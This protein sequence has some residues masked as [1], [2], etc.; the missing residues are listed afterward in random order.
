[1]DNLFTFHPMPPE[2]VSPGAW[3]RFAAGLAAFL[4]L[5]L[6][7]TRAER[8]GD[9]IEYGAMAVALSQHGTPDVRAADAEL[10][11]QYSP[12]AGIA[13]MFERLRD[14]IRRGDAVPLPG[15]QR[16]SGGTYSIHFFAYPALAA[17]PLRALHAAG[18]DPFKAFQIVNY[19]ALA[20]LGLALL[21]LTAS[22][23]RAA[24]AFA[25]VLAGG[26][27]LYANWCSPEILSAALLLSGLVLS[28]TGRPLAGGLLAGVAAMH[29]PSIVC[30]AVCAPLLAFADPAG[31][32]G[33]ARPAWRRLAA[34]SLLQ[35]ALAA[36]PF[37]FFQWRFGTP[38]LIGKGYTDFHLVSG[39]RLVSYY[40]DLNQGMVVGLAAI[41]LL[42][43]AGTRAR[44][45][46]TAAALAVTA[47]F[48][49]G[50]A[51][52]TLVMTNWNAGANGMLRY[53][54]WG[55]APLLYL[56]FARWRGLARWPVALLALVLV[57]QAGL[58]AHARRYTPKEFSPL[59][60]AVL[61]HAPGLYN[62]DPDV[63]YKRAVHTDLGQDPQR[64]A[65]WPE[66]GPVR[67]AMFQ[68]GNP[69][70][71]QVLC[72]PGQRLAPATA[73]RDAGGGWRYVDG[74]VPCVAATNLAHQ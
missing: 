42:L 15:F 36:L 27:I 21:R 37:V 30:F 35:V 41:P 73:S 62:P 70:V 20:A 50:L 65:R 33:T 40:F 39:A 7:T 54:L 61:D 74:P 5:M 56:V 72:G 55:A 23:R 18:A 1:M 25:L 57:L 67:K 6:A 71:D 64:V 48:M 58:M 9:F 59:A 24:C 31:W 12:E 29:N 32:H 60:R 38:S 26:G 4:L 52:P 51:L 10:A 2:R 44:G 43:L 53:A 19:A 14:G 11:R 47:V 49:L 46:R 13:A 8:G 16:A 69:D 28:T 3:R 34:G 22:A 45:A 66:Q 68:A 63:F 17:L